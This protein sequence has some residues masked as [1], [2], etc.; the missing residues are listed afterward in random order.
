MGSAPG[1]DEI[2]VHRLGAIE[3]RVG[4]RSAR[5]AEKHHV[6][7]RYVAVT[8]LADC[9]RKP[10]LHPEIVNDRFTVIRE[11][12]GEWRHVRQHQF[13][14]VADDGTRGARC[15][16]TRFAEIDRTKYPPGQGRR[17]SHDSEYGGTPR[18]A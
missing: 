12:A 8:E 13:G 17:S 16:E 9:P 1:R 7:N 4:R 2:N 18:C 6:I 10:R 15:D 14:V 3:E 5:C 11:P